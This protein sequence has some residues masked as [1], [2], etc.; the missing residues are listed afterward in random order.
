MESRHARQGPRS[1]SN[2]TLE[3]EARFRKT[4]DPGR[5]GARVAVTTQVIGSQGINGNQNEVR[6]RVGPILVRSATTRSEEEACQ[7]RAEPVVRRF[8]PA[9]HAIMLPEQ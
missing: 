1:R 7:Q 9:V 6:L 4:V 2:R 3:K 5:C 8:L